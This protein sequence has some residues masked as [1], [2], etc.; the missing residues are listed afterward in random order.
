MVNV[1]PTKSSKATNEHTPEC[2]KFTSMK[3]FEQPPEHETKHEN[4]YESAV[5]NTLVKA[6]SHVFY[7]KNKQEVKIKPNNIWPTVPTI[8]TSEPIIIDEQ[9]VEAQTENNYKSTLSVEQ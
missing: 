1:L 9:K 4:S 5:S 8:Q 3:T 7:N 6:K 2:S